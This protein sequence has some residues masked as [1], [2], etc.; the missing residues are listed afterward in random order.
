VKLHLPDVVP[1]KQ[2]SNVGHVVERKDKFPIDVTQTFLQLHK[3]FVCEVVAI[4]FLSEVR[5][6]KEE[7]CSL[8]I[9]V[10]KDLLVR[11]GIR[12]ERV[13]TVCVR[14]QGAREADPG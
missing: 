4:Q 7:Q 12:F 9:E 1:T 13:L 2:L 3:I 14:F 6:I 5:R 10:R 8:S 11:A